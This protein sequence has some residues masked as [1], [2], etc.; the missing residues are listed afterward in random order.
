MKSQIEAGL[1]CAA[2]AKLAAE[3]RCIGYPLLAQCDL[4][5]V[6]LRHRSDRDD[7]P[8]IKVEASA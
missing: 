7:A 6:C 4:V 1:E 2:T 3:S 8:L 5:D